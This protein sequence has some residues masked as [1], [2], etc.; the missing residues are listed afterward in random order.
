[1]KKAEVTETN[2]PLHAAN[3]AVS[4]T[5]EAFKWIGPTYYSLLAEFGTGNIPLTA[6]CERYLGMSTLVAKNKAADGTI[7]VPVFRLGGQ[8][9]PW[10]VDAKALANLIDEQKLE[11]TRRFLAR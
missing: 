11:A 2:L 1:M 4:P 6:M 5:S 10:L 9:G 8:K 3:D 7:P